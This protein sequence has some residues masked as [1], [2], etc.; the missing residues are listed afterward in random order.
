MSDVLPK[1]PAATCAKCGLHEQ[2]PADHAKGDPAPFACRYCHGTDVR[3]VDRF[4][5]VP[6][7]TY[8]VA[9]AQDKVAVTSTVWAICGTCG[10]ASQGKPA[11][12]D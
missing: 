6:L 2:V 4:E 8:S 7:G 11:Q 5:V 12:K 1:A 9:G 3:I 10:H